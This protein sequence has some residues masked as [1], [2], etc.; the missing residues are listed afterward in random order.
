VEDS[1]T[2]PGPGIDRLR[3]EPEARLEYLLAN[4][5]LREHDDG[6][7]SA[8]SEFDDARD[9][10]VDSYKDS[11]DG[12]FRETVAQLFDLSSDEAAARI[13]ELDLSRW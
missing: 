3:T 13:E 1:Q 12:A 4:D 10:Y 2:A 9:V 8:T 6:T 11:S 5:V 7:I